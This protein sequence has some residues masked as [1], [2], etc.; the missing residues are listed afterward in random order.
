MGERYRNFTTSVSADERARFPGAE[1]GPR[2]LRFLE[3]EVMP[4]VESAYRPS[5][6]RALAGHSLA[7]LFAID[8]ITAGASFDS[9]I[10]I[11]PS[12]GINRQAA[13]ER[14]LPVL[15]RTTGAARRLYISVAND[16]QPYVDA[17][18]RLYEEY[19]RRKP[20]WL[21]TSFQRF[22]IEDHVTT[23]APALSAGMNWL[24]LQRTP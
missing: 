19:N 13:V 17:F 10:A 8:A 3:R 14:L 1:G 16:G 11:S 20:T 22:R 23:V 9:Y 21:T 12:L 24:Y 15:D 4:A 2:F 6:R 18:T 7:G 5:A